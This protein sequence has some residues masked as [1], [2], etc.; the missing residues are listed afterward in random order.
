MA[1]GL[2]HEPYQDLNIKHTIIQ[3]FTS[4]RT[5]QKPNCAFSYFGK[6]T[7]H[8]FA[9]LASFEN[10]LFALLFSRKGMNKKSLEAFRQ[11]LLESE[12]LTFDNWHFSTGCVPIEKKL[13]KN[14]IV[15]AGTISGMIDPFYLNGVSAALISGKIA[16]LFFTD[17]KQ[18]FREFN[19]FTRNFYIKQNLMRISYKL[20]AKKFS[21]PLIAYLNNH[22]K[23]VGVI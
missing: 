9:Y 3:G 4:T 21:F 18:A 17:K 13:V 12:N 7:N 8:E 5:T 19:R 2:E 1:T 22:L 15:L 10:L 16:A 23:W 6:Y 14:G 20:P 11:H